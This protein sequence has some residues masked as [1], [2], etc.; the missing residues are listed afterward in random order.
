MATS[1][2]PASINSEVSSSALSS[3]VWNGLI[4]VSRPGEKVI[5]LGVDTINSPE[6]RSTRAHSRTNRA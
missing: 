5:R 4:G 1:T 3:R 6:P 2:N